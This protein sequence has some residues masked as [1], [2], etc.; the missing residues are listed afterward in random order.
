MATYME[1]VNISLR[2]RPCRISR[3]PLSMANDEVGWVF[4]AYMAAGAAVMPMARWLAGRYGRKT[5]LIRSLSP[6]SWSG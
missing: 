3:A 2:M 1:A 4:T 5:V 6:S